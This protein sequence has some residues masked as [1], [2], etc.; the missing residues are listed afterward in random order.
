MAASALTMP[1]SSVAAV[2]Y[3]SAA[4]NVNMRTSPSVTARIR[5]AVKTG[6]R[7]TVTTSVSG[8]AYSATC[9]GKAVRG[10]TWYRIS[11]IGGRT[12]KALYGISYVYGASGLFKSYVAPPPPS[13]TVTAGLYGS[14]VGIDSKNNYQVGWTGNQQVSHRFRASTTSTL[15]SVAINQRGGP[16]YSGGTG[17]S[18]RMEVRTDSGGAP[19]ST[20][21]ASLTFRASNPAGAWEQ[22]RSYAFAS[23]PNL[24]QGNL[25]HIVLINTDPAPTKNYVSAN[26]IFT[27]NTTAPRQPAF[28]DDFAVL[29]NSGAGWKVMANDTPVMDLAYGNGH[30][31]GNAYFGVV[32]DFKSSISGS[33]MTRERFTVSGA[34]RTVRSASVRVKHSSGSSPLT[35]RLESSTG[36]VLG[37]GS[38]SAA[39]IPLSST[40]ALGGGRWVTV[41]FAAPI[42]LRAGS[43]YNLRLSTS[44][45]TQYVA[46]PI[47][48]Q[49]STTP[50]WGSHAFRDGKAQRIS[51]GSWADVYAYGALDWQFY[52]K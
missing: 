12:V 2:V 19:S 25:Y 29:R 21:L 11:A 3:K 14:G 46:V 33:S 49:E 20:V 17:G 50:R 37:S 18:M 10:G 8:S 51:G 41:T 32:A 6:T 16:G 38:A 4:C 22:Q 28:S 5:T 15:Q 13:A 30:H 42:R 44:S 9:A 1:A 36:T 23:P 40:S 39:S 7:V 34:D 45:G 52:L 26:E 24:T 27:Y 48:E 35:I 43:T 31:D 47:R